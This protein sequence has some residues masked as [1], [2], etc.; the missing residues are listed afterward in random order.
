MEL[1]SVQSLGTESNV[2]EFPFVQ[3]RPA[4]IERSNLAADTE[5]PVPVRRHADLFQ[6]MATG[7]APSVVADIE[8]SVPVADVSAAE[9]TVVARKRSETLNRV[10]NVSI[11]VLALVLLSPL[12]LLV[13]LAVRLTSVGPVLYVQNRV[14]MD[15]RRRRTT[16]VFDRRRDDV[17]GRE[18]RIYKFRSMRVDAEQQCGAV[19][20]V[21]NDPRVTP[22]GR[23]LRKTRLDEIPQLFNVIKGDMN[24]VGPRPERPSIFAELR[25]NIQEY[26][27]RQQARPGITG[28]AQ[29]NHSY[30]ASIEDVRTKVRF[31]LEYLERQSFTEDLRI[32]V[33]TLP[34]MLFKRGAC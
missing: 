14:G 11:A 25:Q 19:W 13:A 32:M 5:V 10:A 17:G 7:V 23:F 18:F 8:T 34:V 12:L 6:L 21:Q 4:K 28:W 24:I 27:L 20:A 29:I 30:D 26:P 2:I 16:A 3:Q 33:R 1:T 9:L 15:R 31:D 22:V